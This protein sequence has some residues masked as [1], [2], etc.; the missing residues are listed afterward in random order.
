MLV[1]IAITTYM[2]AWQ[3]D[4]RIDAPPT[5]ILYGIFLSSKV[6]SQEKVSGRDKR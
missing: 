5:I 2:V 6:D 1:W 3:E 4:F